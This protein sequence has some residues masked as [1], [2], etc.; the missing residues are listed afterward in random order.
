VCVSPRFYLLCSAGIPPG[1]Y[2]HKDFVALRNLAV[3][4]SVGQYVA[5]RSRRPNSAMAGLPLNYSLN[6]TALWGG[7][8]GSK[9][10]SVALEKAT[11]DEIAAA[12]VS[13]S[14]TSTKNPF[15]A[16]VEPASTKM[17]RR[18]TT[19]SAK[20]KLDKTLDAVAATANAL[21]GSL[22]IDD[23]GAAAVVAKLAFEKFLL[24]LEVVVLYN[25]WLTV[26][27]VC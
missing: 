14:A 16:T 2:L 11:V 25:T 8:T 19:M 7:M 20:I 13:A 4:K 10:Y 12:A 26:D 5:K 9:K 3:Y 17:R 1:A 18:S 24:R 6:Q 23:S 21:G 22:S 15:V 27:Q